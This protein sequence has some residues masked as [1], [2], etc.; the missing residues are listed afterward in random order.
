MENGIMLISW[1]VQGNKVLIEHH[2]DGLTTADK[3]ALLECE[4]LRVWDL[5]KDKV[6]LFLEKSSP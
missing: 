2:S 6:R 5:D 3:V 4:K 1:K